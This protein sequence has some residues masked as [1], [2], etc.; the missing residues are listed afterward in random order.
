[1]ARPHLSLTRRHLVLSAT[2]LAGL[3]ALPARAAALIRRRAR[4]RGRS[5]RSSCRSIG[6]RSGQVA[7]RPERAGVRSCT[8]AAACSIRT[9]VRCGARLE[10]WQCDALGVYHHP[11]DPRGP[12]GPEFPGLRQHDGRRRR[13]VSLRTIEPVP[14]P[15]RTRAFIS[16]SRARFEPLVTQMYIEGHPLN[17]RD[18]LYQRLGERAVLVTVRLE[19]A[20][21]LEPQA[22]S[23]AK[24]ALF[25]IVLGPNGVPRDT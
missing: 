4:R 19:P 11:R 7:G 17:E 8:W 1:M 16:A 25:D 14:Y 15:G 21:D 3:Q 5:I 12:G 20:P 23:G 13:R 10:I 6:Q 24:R 22:K 9:V 2:A 18:F